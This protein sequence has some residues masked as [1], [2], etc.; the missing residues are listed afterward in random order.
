MLAS[1]LVRN[2]S[3]WMMAKGMQNKGRRG[4]GYA[5]KRVVIHRPD[6]QKS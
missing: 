3:R 6:N 1:S 4:G 5:N 2:V